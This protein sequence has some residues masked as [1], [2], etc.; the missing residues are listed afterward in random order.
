MRVN[1]TKTVGGVTVVIHRV[2]LTCV[3]FAKRC[4]GKW[5]LR[6]MAR[7]DFQ[8]AWNREGKCFAR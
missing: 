8:E 6:K 7:D 1:D 3:Y 4:G 5:G 2:T